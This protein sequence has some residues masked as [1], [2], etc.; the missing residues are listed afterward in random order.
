[1]VGRAASERHAPEP[2]P[3]HPGRLATSEMKHSRISSTPRLQKHG[4]TRDSLRGLAAG[5]P[6]S[7]SA[8]PCVPFVLWLISSWGSHMDPLQRTELETE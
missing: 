1:M 4:K 8:F 3:R 6:I 7:L 5:C 2:L